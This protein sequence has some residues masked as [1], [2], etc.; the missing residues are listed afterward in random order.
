MK[1]HLNN[2]LKNNF[3]NLQVQELIAS[4]PRIKSDLSTRNKYFIL[5]ILSNLGKRRVSSFS[6]LTGKVVKMDNKARIPMPNE[7]IDGTHA[8]P[9]DAAIDQGLHH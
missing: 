7:V 3:V 6:L 5:I 8:L 1:S 9:K 2:I 4:K